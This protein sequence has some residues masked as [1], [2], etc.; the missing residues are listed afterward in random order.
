MKAGA[1][2][3][4]GV[5]GDPELRGLLVGRLDLRRELR[6]DGRLEGLQV[7]EGALEHRAPLRQQVVPLPQGLEPLRQVLQGRRVVRLGVLGP[8]ERV[9]VF[10]WAQ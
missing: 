9:L 3:D 5:G 10:F 8:L 2:L 4:H 7:G 6:G 1:H